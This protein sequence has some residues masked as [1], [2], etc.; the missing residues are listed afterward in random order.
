MKYETIE[1]PT[2][3]GVEVTEFLDADGRHVIR[4]VRTI[5]ANG[6]VTL[7]RFRIRPVA[8]RHLGVVVSR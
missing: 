3:P 2:G 7:E 1:R 8:G 5:A 4:E 6:E